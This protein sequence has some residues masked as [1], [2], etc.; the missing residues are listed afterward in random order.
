MVK[1]GDYSFLKNF[2]QIFEI[3]HHVSFWIDFSRNSDLQFVSV[4]MD[5]IAGARV[6]A[7]SMGSFEF[8]FLG[9]GDQGY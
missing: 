8:N 1:I 5:F 7:D 6:I 9:D 4:S 2:L 3:H